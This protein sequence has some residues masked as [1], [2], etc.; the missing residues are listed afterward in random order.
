MRGSEEAGMATTDVKRAET[1]VAE[2]KEDVRIGVPRYFTTAGEHPFDLV[3]WE[4]RDAVIAGKD[5]PS[6]EQRGVEFPSFWSQTATN[7]VAQK[8][9]RGKLGSPERE[10]SVKQMIGRVA[11]TITGWG[12][13][14]G[15]F[16]D[17]EQAETFR[18][19]LTHLLLNQMAAFNSPVWFN[20]GFEQEPQCSAC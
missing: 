16:A 10:H 19:E 20:V 6:F 18:A 12:A 8:Y 3:E 4:E 7:I 15:Y 17:D 1:Q 11:D 13:A 5:D 2:G 14:E 9:F